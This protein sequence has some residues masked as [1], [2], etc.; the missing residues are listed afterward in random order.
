MGVAT[1]GLLMA[2]VRRTFGAPAS[3][4][5]GLVM[6][7]T[8]AAV[9][10][11]RYNNPDALLT[12]LLVGAAYALVRALASDRLRWVAL[13]GVLVGLAFN[14][15]LLQ[16][17]LVLPAFAITFALCAPGSIRRRVAGL[18]VAAVAVVVGQQL[19]GRGDGAHPGLRPR[20]HRRQ[21]EQLG[22][23]PRPRLRRPRPHLRPGRRLGRQR[24]PGRWRRL[25]RHARASC[26]CS[27]AS[28][29]ARSP[30][31]CRPPWSGSSR[32]SPRGSGRRAPTSRGPGSSCGASGSP[33]TPSSSAS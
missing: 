16:A 12:L 24:R 14:T 10:I 28:S 26:G 9:L 1:V 8:P 3:I 5:A 22:A 7:L 15:K 17:Y 25:L 13:A 30:G 18:A 6:A 19:V 4:I 27:T 29:A 23:R 31:S 20:L 21:H 33:S 32:G 11:F 2:T